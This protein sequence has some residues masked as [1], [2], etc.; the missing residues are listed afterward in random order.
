MTAYTDKACDIEGETTY[1]PTKASAYLKKDGKKLASIDVTADYTNYGIPKTATADIYAQPVKIQATLTQESASKFSAQLTITDETQSDNN[2]SVSAEATLSNAINNYTDFD[3]CEFNNLKF[4]VDQASLS[5]Q[6]SVDLKTLNKIE[7]P[8]AIDINLCLD[9]AVFYNGAKT[10][11]L[12][13][14]DLGEDRYL[15][16]VYKDGTKENTNVYYDSF[17]TNVENMFKK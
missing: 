9:A 15:Y 2:L 14:V 1:L 12:T 8:S 16:I 5:I 6:G 10:G 17:I 11:T 7:D 13:V 4:T 3:D